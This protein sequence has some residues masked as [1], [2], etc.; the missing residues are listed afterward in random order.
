MCE[1][2]SVSQFNASGAQKVMSQ[3]ADNSRRLWHPIINETVKSRVTGTVDAKTLRSF[4]K[5]LQKL[6]ENPSVVTDGN[7]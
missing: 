2:C 7:G 1:R 4:S 3:H 5:E 6:V